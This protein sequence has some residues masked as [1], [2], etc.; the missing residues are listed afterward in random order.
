[1]FTPGERDSD[2]AL[3]R[4]QQF[5]SQMAFYYRRSDHWTIG[6]VD[7]DDY[8]LFLFLVQHSVLGSLAFIPVVTGRQFILQ[9]LAVMLLTGM[10]IGALASVFS[11]RKFL[12][13]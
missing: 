2:Y 4:C 13:F 3:S 9:V 12:H 6:S 11:V 1:M 7:C 5:F 10:I 8:W